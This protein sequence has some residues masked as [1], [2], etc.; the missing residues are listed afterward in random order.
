[1]SRYWQKKTLGQT[2]LKITEAAAL[3]NNTQQLYKTIFDI[4]KPVFPFDELGLFALDGRGEMHYELIDES[5]FDR[6]YS[7]SLVEEKLGKYTRYKPPRL[8]SGLAD[9]KWTNCY[10]HSST[11]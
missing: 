1:M 3:V 5:V 7:Q 4:I 8:V 9:G 11:G 10:F 6:T 2:L